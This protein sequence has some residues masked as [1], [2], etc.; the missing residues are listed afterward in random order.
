MFVHRRWRA[1]GH[2]ALLALAILLGGGAGPLLAAM[3]DV[4][5][6]AGIAVDITA[7]TAAKARDA[8]IA[9]GHAKGF[10][11]LLARLTLKADHSRL[12]DLTVAGIAAYVT[13]FSV[14]NEKT[15]STRYLARLTFRFKRDAIRR[16]LMD[17]RLPFAE[18]P[19]K[20]VLVL[21]VFEEAGAVLLWDT[22]N[23]WRTAWE[24]TPAPEGLVPLALPLG[25]LTDIAAIGA[26]QAVRGDAQRLAAVA[27]RYGAGDSLVAHAIKTVKPRDNT[28]QID[29]ST[30]RYGPTGG[31]Q[32][33]VRA[34]TS[35]AGET[36]EAVLK[37]AAAEIAVEVEDDW[38]RDNLLQFGNPAVIAITIPI[39]ALSEWLAVRDRLAG[40][41][42]IHSTDVVL[43]SR[44]EVRA[45]LQFV[46]TTEQ[47]VLALAQSD[48][49]LT[50]EGGWWVLRS[51][52]KGS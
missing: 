7:E 41:A 6:V 48:L 27:Q 37:R 2:R 39:G 20:P 30:T 47:L 42:V 24:E 26:E 32:T 38:K 11:Q 43:L 33:L 21:P 36:T 40:M 25:D 34:Y 51:L 5:E 17:Y 46:G 14:A 28:I 3:P 44:T 10:R 31:G 19:S 13:D 22:P 8:A 12:P 16:L 35:G 45:N 49:A 23:P 15:S 50:Q 9:E 4:Y 18:T 29:V 1:W 52:R